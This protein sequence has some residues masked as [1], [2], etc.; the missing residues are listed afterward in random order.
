MHASDALHHLTDL[1]DAQRATRL[2]QYFKTGK[3]EYG[4]GDCF[5][6]IQ[7]PELRKA[8]RLFRELALSEI[9]QLL[10]SPY[11][12][13]RLLA[14]F[15]LVQ[16]FTKANME[17][18]EAIFQMY[19]A[20]TRYINNW[21][22]VDSSAPRIVGGWLEDKDRSLLYQL[23]KSPRLWERRIAI[24]ATSWFIQ[25]GDYGDTLALAQQLLHDPEDLIHKA[26]GWMLR[27]IGKRDLAAEEAFLKQH[28]Q[29]MP[30]TML[31]YAIEKFSQPHRQ[32][33]LHG[34]I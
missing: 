26:T 22:L 33:Y 3:G 1:A 20:N 9:A 17:T 16:R 27:E 19:M 6:G 8:A 24:M 18:R 25:C 2:Q 14:L 23:V 4:A 5:L 21:D 32:A 29:A 34:T 30:R 11:H 28:Y 10:S 13:A 31:R 12:E 7:V 15:I